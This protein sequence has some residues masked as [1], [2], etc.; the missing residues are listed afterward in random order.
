MRY[1]LSSS[2]GSSSSSSLLSHCYTLR[3]SVEFS[4]LT[5]KADRARV[6]CKRKKRTRKRTDDKMKQPLKRI[7]KRSAQTDKERKRERERK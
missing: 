5:M 1:E 6:K 4:E 7:W 2:L 3:G